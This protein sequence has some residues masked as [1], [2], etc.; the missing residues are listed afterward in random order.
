MKNN[1]G[2]AEI[3]FLTSALEAARVG[4]YCDASSRLDHPG[5]RDRVIPLSAMDEQLQIFVET[6]VPDETPNPDAQVRCEQSFSELGIFDEALPYAPDLIKL[7]KVALAHEGRAL[8][9]YTEIG[10]ELPARM[11]RQRISLLETW[12]P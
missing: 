4:F 12:I 7:T 3:R 6:P 2:S 1:L 11:T 9:F 8:A 10:A 5:D